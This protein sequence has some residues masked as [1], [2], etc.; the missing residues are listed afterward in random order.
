LRNLAIGEPAIDDG[1]AAFVEVPSGDMSIKADA[2]TEETQKNLPYVKTL[3]AAAK[4]L[5]TYDHLEYEWVEVKP[6]K[7]RKKKPRK[8]KAKSQETAADDGRAESYDVV[9]DDGATKPPEPPKKILK[10]KIVE[11]KPRATGVSTNLRVKTVDLSPGLS[12]AIQLMI[13]AGRVEEARRILND[14]IKVLCQ[15][16]EKIFPGA[17]VVGAAWH[18]RSG[19]LHLDLWAHGTH[20]EEVDVGIKK[21]TRTARLWNEDVMCH[22]GPGPGVC[23]WNRHLQA[24]GDE[25][26]DL[27]PGIVDEVTRAKARAEERGAEREKNGRGPGLANRDI[28]IHEAFDALVSAALPDEFVSKGMDVYRDYLREFYLV[29]GDKKMKVQQFDEMGV[30]IAAR[31]DKAKKAQA[32]ADA[33][34]EAAEKAEKAAVTALARAEADARKKAEPIMAAARKAEAA[35][36]VRIAEAEIHVAKKVFGRVWPGQLPI[37]GTVDGILGE[38]DSGLEI[39]RAKAGLW[40]RVAPLLKRAFKSMTGE[41]RRIL[42]MGLEQAKAH[43]NK[44]DA[45]ISMWGG[46]LARVSGLVE[47]SLGIGKAKSKAADEK[48]LNEGPTQGI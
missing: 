46:M 40:D 33:A 25:A 17:K 13:E 10:I 34:C 11:R 29:G 9:P 21:T 4:I 48:K 2:I 8:N 15:Q 35:L 7:G 42:D 24:L 19:Q 5:S 32:A 45:E 36:P 43:A 30:S 20:L 39:V 16:F 41:A 44:P 3:N 47:G 14:L 37:A 26:R 12:R 38:I 23:A 22:F 18:V 1:T 31:L 27:C 28:A 6:K